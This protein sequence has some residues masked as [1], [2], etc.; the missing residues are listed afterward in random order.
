[1]PT[2]LSR[3]YCTL[4]HVRSEV[5]TPADDLSDDDKFK[6]AINMASRAIDD[7]C[8]RDFWFHDHAS[9]GLVIPADWAIGPKIY[10]PW[11]ILTL[12]EIAYAGTVI[13]AANW[14]FTA[15][16]RSVEYISNFSKSRPGY[17]LSVKGTFGYPLAVSDPATTPPPTLPE[18]VRRACI[19]IA[20]AWTNEVKRDRLTATGD[21]VSMLDN[22]IPPEA[23]KLLDY[24]RLDIS[25]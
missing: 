17:L 16:S 2:T 18:P 13:D 1:M 4:D 20:A 24:Y 25:L 7:Y 5:G 15:G 14:M 11:P 8:H 10:F 21:K 12:T 19:Q 3:P 23:M 9:A 6:D 22:R